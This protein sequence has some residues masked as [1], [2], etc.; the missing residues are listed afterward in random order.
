MKI[1]IFSLVACVGNAFMFMK[2]PQQ[3]RVVQ[4][5]EFLHRFQKSYTL[6]STEGQE[7]FKNFIHAIEKIESV[8]S[9]TSN[10][11]L[12]VNQFADESIQTLEQKL[13]VCNFQTPVHFRNA[14]GSRSNTSEP[15]LPRRIDYAEK[16]LISRVKN[17][18]KCGSCW[19]FSTTGALESMLRIRHGTFIDLSEQQLIDCS[20]SNRG[21]NGG[22]MDRAFDDINLM[23]GLL[24]EEDYPYAAVKG[25]CSLNY[26]KVVPG[27]SF[28]EYD[29]FEPYNIRDM[30]EKLSSFGPVCSAVEVDPIDFIFY[31]EGIFDKKKNKHRLNHAVLLVGYNT[32]EGHLPFWRIKN[33][34]GESWGEEGY[35]RLAIESDGGEGIAG[36]HL[37]G[38]YMKK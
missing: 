27:T 30:K 6:Q 26:K 8:N 19:A 33:S 2:T 22:L 7:K 28:I 25:K 37:Y 34:W 14:P 31:K 15:V 17:Q 9:H 11:K 18:G 1:I 36:L 21:C 10:Y 38:V 24:K 20:G 29:F 3:Q 32:E 12:A 13:L 16:G 4:F 23:G 5:E 35:M